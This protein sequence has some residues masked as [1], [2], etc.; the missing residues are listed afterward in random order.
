MKPASLCAVL[1]F[2]LIANAK[3]MSE[4]PRLYTQA[5]NGADVQLRVGQTV[6][7]R[8]STQPGTGYGWTA[9][10]PSCCLLV[11][12]LQTAD[13]APAAPGAEKFQEFSVQA[14]AAG[15]LDL[16]LEYRRPWEKDTAPQRNFLL[17]AHVSQ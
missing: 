16:K 4:S 2:A 9:P 14:S 5:D 6:I 8:L 12:P 11:R 7:I 3:A 1:V 13:S 17:H 15:T 10:A